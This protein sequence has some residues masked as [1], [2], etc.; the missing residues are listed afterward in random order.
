M[1]R[2]FIYLR[3]SGKGQVDGDGFERQLIAC[4]QYAD[5]NAIEIVEVFREEGI[6]GGRELDDRPALSELF[7]ALEENGVKTVIVEKLDRLARDLLIQETIVADMQKK[8]YTLFSTTEPDLLSNDPS[9]ILIRQVFGAIAQYE[10]SMIVL[11]LR[12]A[13]Q[14]KKMKTGKGEGRYAFGER[15]EEQRA[16]GAI[17]GMMEQG[18]KATDIARYLNQEEN[19]ERYRTRSGKPWHRSTVA[20]IVARL[21]RSTPPEFSPR[22][23]AA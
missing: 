7:A 6:S 18:W 11:K 23:R 14:R 2:A 8:G 1:I 19:R 5:A 15:I 22:S 4:Q 20:K 16:L 3:V 21:K 9:R 13:R 17:S 10:K 12:G